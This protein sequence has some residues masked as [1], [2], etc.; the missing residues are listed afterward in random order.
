VG[1]SYRSNDAIVAILEYQVSKKLRVGYSYDFTTSE[2]K[3][4]STGSHEIIIG[5]DFGFNVLKMKTP[6]YF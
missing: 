4:Y 2:L 3:N 5:Y 6:R 1:A